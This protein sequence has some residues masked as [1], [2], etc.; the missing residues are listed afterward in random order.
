[1]SSRCPCSVLAASLRCPRG[2]LVVSSRR[3]CSVLTASFQCLRGVIAVSLRC[4]RGVLAVS[5]RRPCGV[6]AASLRCPRGVVPIQSSHRALVNFPALPPTPWETDGPSSL[7]PRHLPRSRVVR[8]AT[9]PTPQPHNETKCAHEASLICLSWLHLAPYSRPRDHLRET[10]LCRHVVTSLHVMICGPKC[11]DMG[12]PRPSV[13]LA[14]PQTLN[15]SRGRATP[16]TLRRPC[17][18]F[19]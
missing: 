2:V 11:R 1:M 14:R 6:L 12:S 5:S 4:P 17:G 13:S 3:P 8:G 16:I 7:R 18:V 15:P 10:A 9:T 19:L